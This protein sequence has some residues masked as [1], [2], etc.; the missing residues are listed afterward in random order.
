MINKRQL[1]IGLLGLFV[2]LLVYLIGRP[3]NTYFVYNIGI[4]WGF[5]NS[6]PKISGLVWDSLPSFLHVFSF[7]LITAAIQSC[8]K[9][10]CFI[11][12]IFWL[13]IECTFELGQKF[14]TLIT[15]LLPDWFLGVPFLEAAHDYFNLGTF[16]Y[17]D[18]TAIII[19]A[20]IAYF[21]VLTT[22]E[23]R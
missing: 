8:G 5:I 17:I 20:V 1:E 21:V 10:G 4:N 14:D 12:C 13:L 15:K 22:M 2:G 16:D 19:G 18:L 3:P 6:L 9:K 23:R 7:I 11:I